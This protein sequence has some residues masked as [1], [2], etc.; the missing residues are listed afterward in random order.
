MPFASDLAR[1]LNL[2]SFAVEG[3]I[4]L[5][6]LGRNVGHLEALTDETI[7][8]LREHALSHRVHARRPRN[9]LSQ[10]GIGADPEFVV[11]RPSG[12]V[13]SFSGGKELLLSYRRPR[14]DKPWTSRGKS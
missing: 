5:H 1:E 9:P 12:T 2:S 14:R 10:I 6:A 7:T 11:I 3:S 13:K 4:A 8:R